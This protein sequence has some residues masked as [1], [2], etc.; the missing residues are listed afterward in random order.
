DAAFLRL[1]ERRRFA[2]L[3]SELGVPFF[4]FDVQASVDTMRKRV[5][6]RSGAGM[7]AS[8]AGIEVLERQL[9]FDE[10]LSD[11]ERVHTITV[12]TESEMNRVSA[13]TLCAPVSAAMQMAR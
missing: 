9:A 13:A 3:A 11:E 10:P 4:L 12:D 7:D 6:A 8:D 2:R 5:T 1:E